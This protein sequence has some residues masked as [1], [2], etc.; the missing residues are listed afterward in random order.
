MLLSAYPLM[1]YMN[2][3][4]VTPEQRK[5]FKERFGFFGVMNISTEL[6]RLC[7]EKARDQF[8][9]EGTAK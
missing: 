4:D 2:S 5:K 7:S 8:K 3:D 6:N 1:Q 9:P